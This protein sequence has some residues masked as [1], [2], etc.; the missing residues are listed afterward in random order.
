MTP[1]AMVSVAR[2]LTAL[3]RADGALNP[4]QRAIVLTVAH[5]PGLDAGTVGAI[6]NVSAATLRSKRMPGY[7]PYLEEHDW[8]RLVD[9]R[10]YAGPKMLKEGPR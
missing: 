1:P 4:T 10:V 2:T 6:V 7:L 3:V 5:R 8:V 9:G